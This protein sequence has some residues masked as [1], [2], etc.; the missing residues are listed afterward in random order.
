MLPATT[1]PSAV[2]DQSVTFSILASGTASERA[3]SAIVDRCG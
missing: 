1:G 2:D 3:F